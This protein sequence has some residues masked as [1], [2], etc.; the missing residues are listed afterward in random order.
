MML[1]R[2]G[3]RARRVPC[4]LGRTPCQLHFPAPNNSQIFPRNQRIPLHRAVQAGNTPWPF[5]RT[6][7][8]IPHR[9]VPKVIPASRQRK[10]TSLGLRPE[11]REAPALSPR[12]TRLIPLESRARH[13]GAAD[14]LSQSSR[15]RVARRR[16]RLLVISSP[17]RRKLRHLSTPLRT[18]DCCA[19]HTPRR[20]A[21]CLEL[22]LKKTRTKARQEECNG[23]ARRRSRRTP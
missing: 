4:L 6:S 23:E 2:G 14:L 5:R 11:C 9:Q 20:P 8:A 1:H 3:T 22:H 18:T 12:R 7:T 15:K 19:A 13:S 21:A 16:R 17:R 10:G